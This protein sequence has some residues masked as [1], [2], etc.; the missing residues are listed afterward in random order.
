MNFEQTPRWG[1]GEPQASSPK[2]EKSELGKRVISD[3]PLYG[4][5]TRAKIEHAFAKHGPART[6]ETHFQMPGG[7][8]RL[9]RNMPLEEQTRARLRYEF[10]PTS[11][12]EL[13]GE[14][15]QFVQDEIQLKQRMLQKDASTRKQALERT[16]TEQ[17]DQAKWEEWLRHKRE[18]A[19]RTIRSLE[20]KRHTLI[21]GLSE[22]YDQ[23]QKPNESFVQFVDELEAKMARQL[24]QAYLDR[25]AHPG[26]PTYERA[27]NKAKERL[28]AAAKIQEAI[29]RASIQNSET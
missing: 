18:E 8:L 21:R 14:E 1:S 22:L 19:E 28:G 6:G 20:Q 3:R 7:D 27:W 12:H 16:H 10:K 9:G 11:E 29:A 5:E 23:H 4:E 15:L 2:S 17:A 24:D 25:R 13:L 26:N